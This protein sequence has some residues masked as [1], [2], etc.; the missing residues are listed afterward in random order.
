MEMNK[1]NDLGLIVAKVIYYIVLILLFLL[2]AIGFATRFF[3][4]TPETGGVETNG[5]HIENIK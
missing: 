5:N 4:P 3:A 2:I 1:R